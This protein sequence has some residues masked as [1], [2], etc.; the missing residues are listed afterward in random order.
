V[1]E[2]AVARVGGTPVISEFVDATV[3]AEITVSEL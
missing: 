1:L 2:D 3:L